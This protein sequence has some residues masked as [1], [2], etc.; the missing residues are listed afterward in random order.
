MHREEWTAG[1]V[2]TH[3]RDPRPGGIFPRGPARQEIRS[4]GLCGQHRSTVV[5]S[6]FS[7]GKP[8]SWGP[9]ETDKSSWPL[10][11]GPGPFGDVRVL[12]ELGCHAHRHP[13]EGS[14]DSV[15]IEPYWLHGQQFRTAVVSSH[16][17]SL[18][19]GAP[20]ARGRRGRIPREPGLPKRPGRPESGRKGILSRHW[21]ARAEGSLLP[22]DGA[23]AC[24]AIRGQAQLLPRNMQAPNERA[25]RQQY[26]SV[27]N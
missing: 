27:S 25:R 5:V 15:F 26:K 24:A 23:D 21:K 4:R 8:F 17:G 9:T 3:T 11:A 16:Q 7:P 22:C 12:L 2:S 14:G 18:Q 13:R 10:E 6:A 20:G 19:S 1:H